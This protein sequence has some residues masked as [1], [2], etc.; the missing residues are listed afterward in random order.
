[1]NAEWFAIAKDAFEQFRRICEQAETASPDAQAILM[2]AARDAESIG[3]RAWARAV[4]S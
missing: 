2:L 4:K 3:V 1:M